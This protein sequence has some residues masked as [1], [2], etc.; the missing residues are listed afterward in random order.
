MRDARE[1][2]VVM[3]W[4]H[5]MDLM[6]VKDVGGT[7]KCQ[8]EVRSYVCISNT[9][10]LSRGMRSFS[11]KFSL[12]RI[13]ATQGSLIAGCEKCQFDVHSYMCTSVEVNFARTRK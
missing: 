7:R 12:T 3:D 11:M 5:A 9:G 1:V 10:Y 13:S 6:A 2:I 8:F 4:R